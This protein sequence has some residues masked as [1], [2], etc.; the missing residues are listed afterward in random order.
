ME[1]P[2]KQ[3]RPAI[4]A[5]S[6]LLH[7]L[8]RI[9]SARCDMSVSR[10]GHSAESAVS[11]GQIAAVLQVSLII[12]IALHSARPI[13]HFLVPHSNFSLAT[14]SNRNCR[15]DSE[16]QH[17][18]ALMYAGGIVALSAVSGLVLNQFFVVG[19]HNGMKVRVAVCSIIYR[20]VRAGR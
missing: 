12:H 9:F 13:G 2:N 4:A 20:K 14:T 19:F 7:I 16:M 1:E 3:P 5:E 10:C 8:A 15:K 18:E 17:S 6:H 11:A